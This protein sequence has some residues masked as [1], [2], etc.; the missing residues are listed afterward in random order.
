M[1]NEANVCMLIMFASVAPQRLS[2]LIV[3]TDEFPGFQFNSFQNLY[4]FAMKSLIQ[5]QSSIE[6]AWF[7]SA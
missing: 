3:C 2:L 6:V 4:A 1:A 5:L 7:D